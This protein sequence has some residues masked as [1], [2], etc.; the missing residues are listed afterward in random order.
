[1]FHIR[2]ACRPQ[3]CGSTRSMSTKYN[4]AAGTPIR[5]RQIDEVVERIL[6]LLVELPPQLADVVGMAPRSLGARIRRGRE[7]ALEKRFGNLRRVG[8][9]GVAAGAGPAAREHVVRRTEI[10]PVVHTS[11]PLVCRKDV[12]RLPAGQA[13]E[14]QPGHRQPQPPRRRAVSLPQAYRPAA[15]RAPHRDPRAA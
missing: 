1:M 9:E 10:E 3:L 4:S 8:R 15:R 2:Y 11:G 6:R 12:R 5:R 13:D 14:H 7:V